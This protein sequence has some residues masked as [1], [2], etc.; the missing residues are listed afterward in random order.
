MLNRPS[1]LGLAQA[2]PEWAGLGAPPAVVFQGGPVDRR[3][4]IGLA[5]FQQGAADSDAESV[6]GSI[7]VLDL[8]GAPNTSGSAIEAVRIFSGY[9]GWGRGQLEGEIL[10]GGWFVV[11]GAPGDVLSAA[12]A[13]LWAAAVRRPG[14]RNG[15]L[16]TDPARN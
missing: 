2:L 6:L 5:R 3:V 13:G 14:G 9:A 12:P 4:A 15:P 16:R 8:G 1:T 7:R 10:G 11:A